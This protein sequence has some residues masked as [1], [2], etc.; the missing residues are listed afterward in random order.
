MRDGPR[1][2]DATTG[3]FLDTVKRCRLQQKSASPLQKSRSTVPCRDRRDARHQQTFGSDEDRTTA[4]RHRR[5][6]QPSGL[7]LKNAAVN[8]E[9][10]MIRLAP[11][12]TRIALGFWSIA[13]NV[14]GSEMQKPDV[15]ADNLFCSRISS[16]ELL[17]P[18]CVLR[19]AQW[20]SL[21]CGFSLARLY[22][23]FPNATFRVS[24]GASRS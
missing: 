15:A 3:K 18:F 16:R 11:M 6:R 19:R 4:A 13:Q 9:A 23:L 24:C 1:V 10:A 21:A 20:R 22:P 17:R 5:Y 7:P 14:A 2:A 8:F 12:A